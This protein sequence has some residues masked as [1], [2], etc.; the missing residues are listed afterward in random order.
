MKQNTKTDEQIWADVEAVFAANRP[1]LDEAEW[2]ALTREV[3][4]AELAAAAGRRP[5]RRVA[6]WAS[7]VTVA[8]VLVLTFWVLKPEPEVAVPQPEHVTAHVQT[9][10]P[11]HIDAAPD[12]SIRKADH[13]YTQI[14][15]RIGVTPKTHKRKEAKPLDVDAIIKD[16][17]AKEARSS[18][19]A[20]ANDES[21][22]AQESLFVDEPLPADEKVTTMYELVKVGRIISPK[23]RAQLIALLEEMEPEVYTYLAEVCEQADEYKFQIDEVLN[24]AD[25]Q[26]LQLEYQ[27]FDE[28]NDKLS[29]YYINA[30]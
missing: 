7:I 8:A 16:M 10:P 30:D 6:L 29:L 11:T 14:E 4:D 24:E 25:Q 21:R 20:R 26:A 18:D 28:V 27:L 5:L 9:Q 19:E 13:V 23:R 15:K 2:E 17:L 12:T 1:A 3:S 22:P